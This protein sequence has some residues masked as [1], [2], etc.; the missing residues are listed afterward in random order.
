MKEIIIKFLDIATIKFIGN[1]K[2]IEVV[3]KYY[4]GLESDNDEVDYT[5]K[6]N[7][8]VLPDQMNIPEEAIFKRCFAGPHYYSWEKDGYKYAYSPKKERGG[9]H[10]IMQKNNFFQITFHQGESPLQ[11]VGISREI[12]EK[13]ALSQGYMPIHA[14]VVSKDDKGYVFFGDRNK[15]KSTSMFSSIIFDGAKPMS[16]DIAMVKEERGGWKVIGW[17]FTVTIDQSYFN[18]ID[19]VPVRNISNNGKI[20]YYPEDFCEEF[21][22]Q[23]IWEQ[24]LDSM[25]H[26]DIDPNSKASMREVSSDELKKRLE[27]YGKDS[28]WK[29]NDVFGLGNFEPSFNYERISKMVN[30][31]IL[32][33]DIIQFFKHRE[34][35]ER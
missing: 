24:H 8:K 6:L 10:L 9:S 35:I 28:G 23:W 14:A 31:K 3:K 1:E 11:I 7:E 27:L 17:P 30:G 32:T 29:W 19:R 20:K 34:D 5:L 2:L 15:G 18:L 13:K 12:L 21:N 33:G 4:T 25:I 26:V 16:S 22:T